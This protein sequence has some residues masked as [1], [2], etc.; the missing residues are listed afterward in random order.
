M[1]L[2][3]AT[4]LGLGKGTYMGETQQPVFW[5]KTI[6]GER[7]GI[8]VHDHCLNVGCVAEAIMASLPANVRSLLPAGSAT[9]AALHDVGKITIGFQTKC[10]QRIV[11]YYARDLGEA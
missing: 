7:P 9:L 1:Q 3:M 5:A 2:F 4:R 8:S 10:P 11:S 6:P